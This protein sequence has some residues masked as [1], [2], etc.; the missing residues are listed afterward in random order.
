M[1]MFIQQK[2]AILVAGSCKTYKPKKENIIK[3]KIYLNK[4]ENGK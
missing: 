3:L 2:K 1:Q 4:L